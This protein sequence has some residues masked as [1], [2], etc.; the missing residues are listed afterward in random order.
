MYRRVMLKTRAA[1][2]HILDAP[3]PVVGSAAYRRVKQ[4]VRGEVTMHFAASRRRPPRHYRI[5]PRHRRVRVTVRGEKHCVHAVT[6]AHSFATHNWYMVKRVNG[7][8][9]F[10]TAASPPLPHGAANYFGPFACTIHIDGVNLAGF[11]QNGT[12][13]SIGF[14]LGYSNTSIP[15]G[16]HYIVIISK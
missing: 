4:G 16:S 6:Q 7:A 2:R 14:V 1:P 12:Q 3:R 13:P 5:A 15:D 9:Q 8:C 10:A 11:Q